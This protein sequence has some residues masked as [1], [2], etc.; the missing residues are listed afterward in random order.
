[1]KVKSVSRNEDY[2]PD[3][4]LKV[5]IGEDGDVSIAIKQGTHPYGCEPFLPTLKFCTYAGRGRS[6]NTLR[7][8]YSLVEAIEKDNKENP[9]EG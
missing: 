2:S 7:A 3:G 6:M 1:M 4:K 5:L 8:L 9:I